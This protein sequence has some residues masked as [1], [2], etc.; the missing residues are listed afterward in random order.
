MKRREK[1]Y[2]IV[3][4][5]AL[6][7]LPVIGEATNTVQDLQALLD[8]FGRKYSLQNV[9]M[10]ADGTV[11]A[12]YIARHRSA[13]EIV[14]DG[15][16]SAKASPYTQV[17]VDD[18][19]NR[20]FLTGQPQAFIQTVL[21]WHAADRPPATVRVTCDVLKVDLSRDERIAAASEAW[22]A[23]AAEKK[24][25]G[26]GKA[27]L[28][29][30]GFTSQAFVQHVA[31]LVDAEFAEVV[32]RQVVLV[33]DQQTMKVAAVNTTGGRVVEGV[34]GIYLSITP[35]ISETTLVLTVQTIVHTDIERSQWFGTQTMVSTNSVSMEV[36]DNE[37]CSVIGL[38]Q[39]QRET[40]RRKTGLSGIPLIG[41]WFDTDEIRTNL[42][43]YI[44]MIKP[45]L[46]PDEIKL[47]EQEIQGNNHASE[48][49]SANSMRS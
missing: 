39:P 28:H 46:T 12:V 17:V 24:R 43:E 31:Y 48:L 8:R 18:S 13:S 42:Y 15:K 7:A 25:R 47:L 5:A 26:A 3:F 29:L 4:A 23:I 49:R 21:A 41:T 38:R 16:L 2:R 34:K 11:S 14:A 10:R 40:V 33:Q 20:I 9:E 6:L 32:T 36:A 35:S 45:E 44:I 30:Q 19:I 27:S 37:L 1:W 22:Q